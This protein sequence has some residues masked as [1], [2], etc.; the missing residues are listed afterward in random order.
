ME[1]HLSMGSVFPVHYGL[2]IE[3]DP[4]KANFKGEEQLQLNVRNSDN[5]NFPKQFTLHGTDLVVL[6]AEL[7]D[8]STGTNFDQFEI[9]YKKEEQEI[10]LKHDMD[11]LSISNN[12]ALKIKYIGKLN[13]IKTHQDK[14]TGVFKTNYMGGYH[15]DQ[16][17]NNIVI[18]TH[19]QPTFARSI[20]PCFDELS[21][22]T[23]FQLSLTSLSRFS[24]ISNSK[25]LKTEERADGGQELKTTHFEKTPLLPASLFGFSI[26][27][28]RKINTV[29][30]FDG[31]STEIGIYSPWRVEEATYS[32][33]IMKKY[34]P[35]LSS[36]F[37]F[38]YPSSK[39]DIVLL[40]F[41]SD[42]AMENF[43]MISIQ[44]AHLLISPSMLANEEVR[45]Q[46]HQ[47]VVHELVHQWI[48][49]Y[50][51]FDSWSHLWFNESFATWCSSH[52]L[53]EN[54]DLADYWNSIDYIENQLQPSIERDSDIAAQSIVEMAKHSEK[55]LRN[56]Y[57][58]EIFDAHSY[59]KG[60]ALLRCFQLTVG[61]D[62]FRKAFQEIF[63]EMKEGNE[64]FHKSAIKP[65]DIFNKIGSFLKSENIP[66]FYTSWTRT[67]GVPIVSVEELDGKTKLIQ[68]RYIPYSHGSEADHED[69]PYYVPMFSILADGSKDKKNILLTDRSLTIDNTIL[70]LNHNGQGY[71]RVSYE[72]ETIY[73]TIVENLQ[74]SKLDDN[75][76]KTILIDLAYF[77]GDKKYQKDVHIKGLFKILSAFAANS[78]V[79]VEDYW[80]GLSTALDIVRRIHSTLGAA[81]KA[82][83]ANKIVDPLFRAMKWPQQ[84]FATEMA[85][86]E[87]NETKV[88]GDILYL[89]QDVKD[90]NHGVYSL[91]DNYFKAI[92]T[93]P[94]SSI[95]IGLIGGVFLLV[96]KRFKNVKQW[97]KLFELVKS[98]RGLASHIFQTF[99]SKTHTDI[100]VI[101]QNIAIENL[102]CSRNE[103]IIRKV[104]NFVATN[105]ESNGVSRA[106]YGL[107]NIGT[108]STIND[109]GKEVGQ[110]VRDVAWQWLESNYDLWARKAM[111]EGSQTAENLSKEL[112]GI[113]LYIFEMFRDSEGKVDKFILR[114]EELLGVEKIHLA[115]IWLTVK[116]TTSSNKIIAGSVKALL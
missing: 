80:C 33:D 41:L 101:I 48:G 74:N 91:A 30:E 72:S 54:G 12:A 62:M 76:L 27:D 16:K 31:I 104:L 23:T 34:I 88:R 67:S 110:Q 24:A 65:I 38:S 3:I 113:I 114:K 4:A 96:S 10:V 9:T 17:S 66:K 68:H 102:A 52:I 71:F 111:R 86:M 50:I 42:M 51:S 6:S 85:S 40:P 55:S 39:L 11:N 45:K 107:H 15:D 7:M 35:L 19:C 115:Q 61:S 81:Q 109:N 43:G 63:R 98:S 112:D 69:I 21:S 32:L 25:V 103:E 46:L 49:N 79:I 87:S 93:G 2:Q 5:I 60:I 73:D 64:H 92:M 94:A 106:L 53:E 77:I 83:L 14:T 36:Y 26:G 89:L 29:T 58:H 1:E 18:S 13:D 82:K 108:R 84:N 44:V 20:F 47:L 105:I 57:T 100:S 90:I 97:K 56:V 22:K 8:D 78:S 99:D 59:N 70:M 37:N 95:P 116:E 28:F 75:N